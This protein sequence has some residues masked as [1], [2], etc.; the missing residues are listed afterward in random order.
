MRPEKNKKFGGLRLYEVLVS[1]LNL[2]NSN[3]D[4]LH[5]IYSL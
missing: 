3:G 2:N 1:V 4:F 5:D